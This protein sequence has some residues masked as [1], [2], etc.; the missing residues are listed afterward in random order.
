MSPSK[1]YTPT[2][3]AFVGRTFRSHREYRKAL[4]ATKMGLV[5]GGQSAAHGALFPQLSPRSQEAYLRSLDALSWMR[6]EGIS[7]TQA[8]RRAET[9]P[10][11]VLKYVGRAIQRGKQG[12]YK[13]RPFDRLFRPLQFL[14]SSGRITL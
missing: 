7:L 6:S 3:G 14:T 12:F 5:H 10:S 13:A 2:R 1:S 4:V 8:A 11:T 9:R